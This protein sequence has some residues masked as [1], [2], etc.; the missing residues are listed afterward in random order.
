MR[1]RIVFKFERR[2]LLTN[3]FHGI[4]YLSEWA[5]VEVLDNL[6]VFRRQRTDL[7]FPGERVSGL[8][9]TWNTV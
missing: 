6:P 7:Q 3:S 5:K 4:P 2:V 1:E 9:R 8:L